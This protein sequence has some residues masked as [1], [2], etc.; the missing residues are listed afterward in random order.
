MAGA[1]SVTVI[2]SPFTVAVM[3]SGMGCPQQG[4]MFSCWTHAAADTLT[5]RPLC[6]SLCA[7]SI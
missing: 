5:L 6:R 7:C 4:H 2:L 1:S 3:P